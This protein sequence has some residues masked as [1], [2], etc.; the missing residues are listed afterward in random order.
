MG[1]GSVI[2]DGVLQLTCCLCAGSISDLVPARFRFD[3]VTKT[4]TA[5][6]PHLET[7]RDENRFRRLGTLGGVVDR[8]IAGGALPVLGA[9]LRLQRV[10]LHGGACGVASS[11]G[12]GLGGVQPGGVRLRVLH[13]RGPVR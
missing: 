13:R 3:L 12:P 4:A 1:G 5:A 6:I 2:G 8:L 11:P 10:T 7:S 9:E